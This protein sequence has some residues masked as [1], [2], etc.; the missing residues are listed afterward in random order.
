MDNKS[1]MLIRGEG[2]AEEISPD[3]IT[4]EELVSFKTQPSQRIEFRMVL[5]RLV[6]MQDAGEVDVQIPP[7]MTMKCTSN[8]NPKMGRL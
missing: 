4:H 1:V 8:S 3:T 2:S 5:S 7:G 6:S